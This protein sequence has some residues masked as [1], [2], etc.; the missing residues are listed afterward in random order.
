M[1]LNIQ[2]FTWGL[3][4]LGDR[5]RPK[6]V[7]SAPADASAR[8]GT[9]KDKLSALRRF[10]AIAG[11]VTPGLTAHVARRLLM[12]PHEH[13]PRAWERPALESAKRVTFRFGLSGLHWGDQGPVVL[14][15]HG[16]EGRPTQFRYFIEP[17][18]AAGRQVIALDAPA[19]GETPGEEAHPM[20]FAMALQEAAV[21]IRNLEAVIGHSMGAGAAAIALANGLSAE[22]A[23]LIAGP[24]S[25]QAVLEQFAESIG[26]PTTARPR[27][28]RAVERHTG[29]PVD[30]ISV[31]GLAK[32]LRHVEALIV[33]DRDDTAVPFAHATAALRAWPQAR[34]LQTKGLGH[35]RVLTDKTVVDEVTRFLTQTQAPLARPSQKFATA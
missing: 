2:G 9:G 8:G 26:L 19:H 23:V 34:L 18:L 33:H 24:S 29:V 5:Q 30:E 7:A 13:E 4:E 17:L 25:V 15:M 6:P 3:P 14:M 16:W 11:R 27:F 28:I 21:E 22:R 35:W 31:K 32:R 12:T 20:A 10:N 1:R